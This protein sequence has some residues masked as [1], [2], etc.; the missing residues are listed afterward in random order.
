MSEPTLEI[1][2]G[3][4]LHE[5]LRR[6]LD[7]RWR[8]SARKMGTL[9]EKWRRNEEL[10]QAWAPERDVDAKRRLLREQSGK[11]QYTTIILPYTYAMQMSA[12]SYWTTVFLSRDPIL[13]FAGRHGESEQ[14]VQALEALIAYQVQVGEM[15]VPYYFWLHD[16]GRYGLG[17][18]G[19][20]WDEEITSVSRYVEVPQTLYGLPI[21]GPPQRTLQ[22][23]QVRGYYGNKIFNIRPY[24]YYPDPRVPLHAVQRGEFVGFLS[25]VG[26]HEISRRAAS[27]EYVNTKELRATG[28]Q[29][30]T[31][32]EPGATPLE[33][34]NDDN[35]FA[36]ETNEVRETGPYSIVTMYVDLSPREWGLSDVSSHEKWVFEASVQASASSSGG[37]QGHLKYIHAARPLGCYH[38]KFP[39][40]ILEMDPEPY[41]FA[42]RGIPEIMQAMQTTMD[43]LVNSHMYNVRKTLNNQWLVDPSRVLMTDFENPEAGGAIKAKPAAYGTDLRMAVQQLPVADVTRGHMAD[44]PF[45]HEFSQRAI[46]VN[47]Q[48]MAMADVKSH[49][50]AGANRTASSFGV[51]R[52]K[53]TAEFMSA[54]GWSPLGQVLVQNTQQYMDAPM[55]VRVAGD[56]LLA[57]GPSAPKFVQVTPEDI[58]GFFDFVP[59][60][61]TMPVDR[62]AQAALWQQLFG[63]MAKMPGLL[64][65]YDV[66]GIF[67]WVAQLAGLKNINRF[68]IQ[69]APPGANPNL[70]GQGNVVPLRG[71]APAPGNPPEPGQV[72]GMGTT[73]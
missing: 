46:G 7:D 26:W 20:Y 52:Q 55:K 40:N 58:Q 63:A 67:S 18:L 44:I 51:N 6:K 73:A 62:Y 21:G 39:I 54:M 59:V 49:T 16:A 5:R 65:Q 33:L 24:D 19:N 36:S 2:V 1:A 64:Q 23:E 28:G 32:R 68:R 17:I 22:T 56:L 14:Q 3:S 9:H 60:D 15:L 61:G 53:T 50:T 10:Q 12:W 13:Q 45:F 42:S 70:L 72:P 57:L 35:S 27:G 34:P 29:E 47:D 48:M 66:A 11:P 37:N 8:T 69:I 43:W 4:E 38:N 71:A 41:A 30:A 31:A 25:E